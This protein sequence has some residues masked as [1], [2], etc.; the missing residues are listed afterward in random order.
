MTHGAGSADFESLRSRPLTVSGGPKGNSLLIW[1]VASGQRHRTFKGPRS[2]DVLA[3]AVSPDGARIASADND[4]HASIIDA[5]TGAE[6][7]TF[8]VALGGAKNGDN[9]STSTAGVKGWC[10]RMP[11]ALNDDDEQM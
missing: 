11:A 9:Y 2:V 5:A 8:R 3:I 10:G 6:V 4:G 7:Y 1:N